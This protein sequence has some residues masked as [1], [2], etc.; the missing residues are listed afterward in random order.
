MQVNLVS[1]FV[2]FLFRAFTLTWSQF[3]KVCT[4][5]LDTQAYSKR[6]MVTEV[7]A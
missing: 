1:V 7:T 5:A 6:A 3:T 2:V 4:V